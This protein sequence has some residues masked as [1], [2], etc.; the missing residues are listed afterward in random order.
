[1][2]P[3]FAHPSDQGDKVTNKHSLMTMLMCQSIDMDGYLIK[4]D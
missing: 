2:Q 1:M 4:L 3:I